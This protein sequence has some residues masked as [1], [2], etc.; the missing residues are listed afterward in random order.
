MCSSD[1]GFKQRQAEV[2]RERLS[3]LKHTPAVTLDGHK[4]ELLANIEMPEDAVAALGVGSLGVGLFR[5]EFLFMGRADN[6]PDE[7]EQFLAYRKAVEGMKGLPVTIRTVDIGA[8]KPL[9][10]SHKDEDHLNPALGLRAIR[11][12]LADPDMFLTQ[13]RAILDRKST[14]L[15]SSH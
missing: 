11:W 13:L 14:R 6:L 10:R 2:E 9:D 15:N 4:V 3:R 5:S 1:L 12:S 7:E 8:D